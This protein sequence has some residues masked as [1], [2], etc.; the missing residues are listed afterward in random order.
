MIEVLGIEFT[1]TFAI[2]PQHLTTK[3][4]YSNSCGNL[5]GEWERQ[6]PYMIVYLISYAFEKLGYSLFYFFP[7]A[8]CHNA[9]PGGGES[10]SPWH[11]GQKTVFRGLA[12]DTRHL[13]LGPHFSL[14]LP[15]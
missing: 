12:S 13:E 6:P 2:Q 10:E 3:Y 1:I 15:H 7:K 9:P 8:Q 11:L 5:H 14:R 4:G